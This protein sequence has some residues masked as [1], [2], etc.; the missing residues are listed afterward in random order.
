VVDQL[1]GR[2]CES[3]VESISA[4]P[5]YAP[6]RVCCSSRAT[7][8]RQNSTFRDPARLRRLLIASCLAYRWIVYLSV[9]DNGVSRTQTYISEAG[10]RAYIFCMSSE[11]SFAHDIPDEAIAHRRKRYNEVD[12][13]NFYGTFVPYLTTVQKI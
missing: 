1:P 11:I 8:S 9:C 12:Q 2:L 7:I 4:Q 5:G 3:V 10:S 13:P 6:A